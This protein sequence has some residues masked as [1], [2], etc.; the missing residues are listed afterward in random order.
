MVARIDIINLALTHLAVPRISSENDFSAAAQECSFLYDKIRE[1]ELRRNPWVFAIRRATLYPVNT[2]IGSSATVPVTNPGPTM[3]VTFETWS[4]TATY[5][6]GVIVQYTNAAGVTKLYQSN[7]EFNTGNQPDTSFVQWTTYFGSTQAQPWDTTGATTYGPGDL[8]FTP[9]SASY[10]VYMSLTGLNGTSPTAG[11]PTYAAG[12]TYNAGDVVVYSAVN[13]ISLVDLNLGNTPNSSP[14][15]WSTTIP[16]NYATNEAWLL[17]NSATLARQ[18]INWPAGTGPSAQEGSRNIYMLPYGHLAPAPQDPK[19]GA[20]SFLGAPG[21]L[22]Y[23]D[24]TYEDNFFVTWTTGP[25]YYR[26]VANISD[27]SQF[28]AMFVRGFAASLAIAAAPNITGIDP[29][30]VQMAQA[31]YR[32]L[33]FEARL[34]NAIVAG[35]DE[36]AEDDFITCRL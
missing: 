19:A 29:K 16:A 21:G 2:L 5:P 34:K 14:S 12:T 25:I 26:F 35:S 33:M 11:A 17:L 1:Y 28:D 4:S 6:S 3:N 7:V 22:M 9:A 30:R 36:P 15:Q 27:P 8:V 24:W 18:I 32:Q 31:F 10:K 13:Y 20:T 23:S